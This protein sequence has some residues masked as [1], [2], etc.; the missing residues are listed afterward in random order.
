MPESIAPNTVLQPPG[1]PRPQ[2]FAYGIRARGDMVFV[3]GMVGWDA[4]GRFPDGFVAQ[5]RQALEN[6]VAVLA[7]GGAGPE[8]V[9]R[10]TWYV[11]DMDE[12]LGELAALGAAYREIMGRHFP[13]MA[14]VEVG[15]LVEPQA[16][17]EIEATAVLP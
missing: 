13:A 3:G 14:V 9:V 17:L 4:S 6:I 5:T 2:G 8:H 10:M 11:L 12:Y 15:R 1:W 16:R 7:E